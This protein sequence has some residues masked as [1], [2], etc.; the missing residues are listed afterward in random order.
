MKFEITLEDI[1]ALLNITEAQAHLFIA[2]KEKDFETIMVE[3]S[4]DI[5]KSQYEDFVGEK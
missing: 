2:R 5:I 4:W 3:Y 1:M